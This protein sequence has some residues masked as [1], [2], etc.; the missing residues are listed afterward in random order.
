MQPLKQK[1]CKGGGMGLYG[2]GGKMQFMKQKKTNKNENK[3][4]GGM[5]GPRRKV[6]IYQIEHKETT[7]NYRKK[8]DR[9]GWVAD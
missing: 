2:G 3:C 8:L 6:I 5:E 9:V 4:R 1:Q 7:E